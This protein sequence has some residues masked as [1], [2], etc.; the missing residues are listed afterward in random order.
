MKN[1]FFLI[2]AIAFIQCFSYAQG[3]LDDFDFQ[4]YYQTT[5]TDTAVFDSLCTRFC[6]VTVS[7][8]SD[9]SHIHV[10][11]GTTEG[12]NDILQYSFAFDVTTGL[13]AGLSYFRVQNVIYLGLLKTYQADSYYYEIQLE[14]S[15]G[16]LSAIKKWN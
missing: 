3:M 10:K 8:T 9:L 2:T 4:V 6:K 12:A 5:S 7:D 14:D 11:V 1:L 15:S 13:P 16:N